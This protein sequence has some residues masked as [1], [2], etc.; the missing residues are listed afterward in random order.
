MDGLEQLLDQVAELD[1][2]YLATA[3]KADALVRLSRLVDRVEALRLRVMAAAMDV[4]DVEGAPTVA[5]WLAPRTR[6]TTRSLH[7]TRAAGP[8]AG[9]P[10]AARRGGPG[11]RGGYRWRRPR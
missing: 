5:A 1:P 6:A 2:C 3:E 4:A 9:P 8:R 10:L 7:G 11:R